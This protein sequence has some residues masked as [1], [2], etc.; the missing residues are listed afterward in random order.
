M[1]PLELGQKFVEDARRKLA[2][3]NGE[4]L[5]DSL[6]AD[7]LTGIATRYAGQADR[8]RIGR[9][10]TSEVTKSGACVI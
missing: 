8:I 7:E 9:G 3:T 4:T 10:C 2:K 6:T 1:L 5:P